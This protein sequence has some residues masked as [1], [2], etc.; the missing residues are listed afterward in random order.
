MCFL[1][2]YATVTYFI[3]KKDAVFMYLARAKVAILIGNDHPEEPLH[4]VPEADV[5][6]MT[7]TLENLDFKVF[8]FINLS[9]SEIYEA[10]SILTTFI[11]SIG[12]GVYVMFCYFG[13]GFEEARK[14]YLVPS[15]TVSGYGSVDCVCADDLLDDLQ[16]KTKSALI[17]MAL[18][19][20]RKR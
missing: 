6:L 2:A 19:T 8:S 14:C 5:K 9:K 10:I 11:N 15:D 12:T 1:L 7:T 17:V 4:G 3:H 18:D 20:C 13:H 16:Y